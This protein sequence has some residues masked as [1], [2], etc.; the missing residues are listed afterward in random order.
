MKKKVNRFLAV[1]ASICILVGAF[2]VIAAAEVDTTP[3]A[4][5]ITPEENEAARLYDPIEGSE[6][7]VCIYLS[8]RDGP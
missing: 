2:P 4:I 6:W 7:T 8:M 5:V 3:D 1:F